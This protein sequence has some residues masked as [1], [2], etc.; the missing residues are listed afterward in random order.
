MT[1]LRTHLVEPHESEFIRGILYIPSN[2]DCE[3]RY[4]NMM[5][6]RIA[7]EEYGEM[8]YY[9]TDIS[10]RRYN[11]F[12]HADSYGQ[13]YHKFI[14]QGEF[15]RN[16]TDTPLEDTQ[17]IKDVLY[18]TPFQIS[19]YI[20]NE[21]PDFY[22]NYQNLIT[23]LSNRRFD[24]SLLHVEE[25]PQFIGKTVLLLQL[26]VEKVESKLKQQKNTELPDHCTEQLT[27]YKSQMNQYLTVTNI[28]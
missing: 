19:G 15:N 25:N 13:Y 5:E 11:G 18:N 23:L 22:T 17:L 6:V 12:V 24:N 1:E 27:K 8:P 26:L 14:R 28:K 10:E 3:L 2:P 4:Q 7:N 21:H 20:K 9:Y 16:Y